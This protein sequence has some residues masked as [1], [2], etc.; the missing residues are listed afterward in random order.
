MPADLDKIEMHLGDIAGSLRELI[1]LKKKEVD[2]ATTREERMVKKDASLTTIVATAISMAA[3]AY[4]IKL[5][6]DLLAELGVEAD[7]EP[8]LS[9]DEMMAEAEAPCICNHTRVTHIQGEGQ[10]LSCDCQAFV[11]AVAPPLPPELET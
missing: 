3:S 4:G 11:L 2:I 10:C 1:A 8:E 7:S 5:P 9:H 6:P